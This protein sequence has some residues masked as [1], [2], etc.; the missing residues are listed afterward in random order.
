MDIHTLC[1]RIVYVP[2]V[3]VAAGCGGGLGTVGTLGTLVELLGVG[4]PG[5]SP[6]RVQITAEVQRVDMRRQLIQVETPDGRAGG[7]IY[8]LGTVVLH[9]EQPYPITALQPGDVV[10]LQLEQAAQNSLYASRIEVVE[11][12]REDSIA[13]DTA[14]TARLQEFDGMVGEIDRERGTFE[15]R[16]PDGRTL[17]ISL[18]YNP[19]VV[20]VER[21]QGLQSGDA[22][23][24]EGYPLNGNRVELA[25]FL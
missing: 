18:P 25:R 7:V 20:M 19:P 13:A 17:I 1:R 2:L 9:E 24:V 21:F 11:L 5:S 16:S 4:L 12:A 22:A 10:N 14:A 8:D 3:V 23:R 15:L 6:Q